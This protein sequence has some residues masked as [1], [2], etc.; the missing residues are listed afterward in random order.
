MWISLQIECAKIYLYK[1]LKLQC[2][3]EVLL[4][5]SIRS[6]VDKTKTT[7]SLKGQREKSGHLKTGKQKVFVYEIILTNQNY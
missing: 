3:C 7:K 5:V 6:S 2:L 1:I 4:D